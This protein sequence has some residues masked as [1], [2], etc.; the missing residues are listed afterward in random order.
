MNL[1]IYAI[2]CIFIFKV[3]N[4]LIK[5]NK[6]Q[7]KM[8]KFKNSSYMEHMLGRYGDFLEDETIE[9]SVGFYLFSIDRENKD[10]IFITEDETVYRLSY[11]N[12]TDYSIEEVKDNII[13]ISLHTTFSQK[14][15]ISIECFNKVK[16][17]PKMTSLH[18]NIKSLNDLYKEEISK[19]NRVGEILNEIITT[20]N[21]DFY[22]S[23]TSPPPYTP[24]YKEK[25]DKPL[26]IEIDNQQ[27]LSA[28]E[29]LNK[30]EPKYIFEE[31]IIE[32]PE[33]VEL[34]N[35]DNDELSNQAE[36]Q[37]TNHP[38]EEPEIKIEPIKN[39]EDQVEGKVKISL[40]E[41]EGYSRGK[42][43]DPEIQSV[44]SDA[45]MRGN[46]YIYITQEQMEDLKK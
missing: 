45:K 36:D 32:V 43:L 27:E 29:S 17:L 30:N 21:S 31:E 6:E 44:F 11:D 19:I 3:A 28:N 25:N 34:L 10:F 1:F 42:F 14:P 35:Q 13:R 41:I 7:A 40:T 4:F 46:Q 26:V 23:V 8:E 37:I 38:T 33:T 12:L 2:I 22:K 24:T 39:S 9:S 5:R 20:R 15:V 16:A 18:Q